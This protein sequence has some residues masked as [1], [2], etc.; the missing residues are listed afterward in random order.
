MTERVVKY[1]RGMSRW[2]SGSAERLHDAAMALFAEQG[3]AATT[4]PQIADRAGLTTRSFFRWYPD[5]REVL[6][7]GEEELPGVVA[8][9]FADAPPDLAPLDVVRHGFRAV[10][11]IRL[12]SLKPELL[13]RWRIIRTDEG[14][15]ERHSRKLAILFEAAA[16]GFRDRGL[17]PLDADLAGRLAVM[18][19]DHTAE[20]WLA[21]DA[22]SFADI[23][24]EVCDAL[25]ALAGVSASTPIGSGSSPG[26][27][28]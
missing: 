9:V 22:R 17:G 2:P 18:I 27:G 3:F 16:R 6:F 1:G 7:A 21:Q 8:R 15:R 14:L 11:D 26:T 10:L 12:E 28:R 20:R 13:A 5:K 23:S 24:D 25:G 19:Y 4:V